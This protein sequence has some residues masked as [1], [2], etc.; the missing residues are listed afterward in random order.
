MLAG[1][2]QCKT[3]LDIRGTCCEPENVH[4]L[5]LNMVLMRASM[6]TLINI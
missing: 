6:N 5:V 1:E 2:P 4:D 3:E